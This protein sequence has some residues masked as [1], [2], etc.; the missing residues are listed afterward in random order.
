MAFPRALR[1][2]RDTAAIGETIP[3]L[4]DAVDPVYTRDLNGLLAAIA[5]DTGGKVTKATALQVPA[6]VKAL[7]TYHLIASFPLREYVREDT[8]TPRSFLQQPSKQTTY[9]ALMMRTINDLLMYDTAYWVVVERA[10]DGY[11]AAIEHMPYEQV[12]LTPSIES[13]TA[14]FPN[15]SV[16]W[17]GRTVL[18]RDLIRF[19][20]DGTGGWLTTG[21]SA[22][23]T[24]AGLEAA[25]LRAAE[26]PAPGIVLKNT[27]ADL[28]A[29]QVD[30]LLTAWETARQNRSTAYLNS[31]LETHNVGGW[32]PSDLQLTDAR[33]AAATQ[34]ARLANLDPTWV[35]A[36]VPG[37]SLTYSNRVDLMRQLLDLSLGP[38]M[39]LIEQRLTLTDVTPRGHTVEFESD[40]LLKANTIEL[41]NLIAQQLPLGVITVP[42]ARRMLDMTEM[43]GEDE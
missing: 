7:K 33:N 23:N 43:A 42:E 18:A 3:R 4:T 16:Y 21:A 38:V 1:I 34:I 19:D 28:P 25:A 32:S 12:T 14:E 6:F 8:V 30:A 40:E 36:G 13:A 20:G 27:G 11:P 2:V 35:G 10:W 9:S 15:G 22:I 5:A 31:T 37:A 39:R 26:T 29:T 24:A 17:N 41:G